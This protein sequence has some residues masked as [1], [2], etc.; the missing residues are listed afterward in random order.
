MSV[1]FNDC[2]IYRVE[3]FISGKGMF[4]RQ[5]E[6]MWM[7]ALDD[8]SVTETVYLMKFQREA[9]FVSHLCRTKQYF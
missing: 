9:V 2:L 3:S 1:C 6:G 5:R 8:L 4:N 7:S